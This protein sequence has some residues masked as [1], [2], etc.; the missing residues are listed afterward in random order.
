MD[1]FE[2]DLQIGL[3]VELIAL[4]IIQ[5]K[6]PCAV[7]VHGYKGYDIWIPEI[8]K[9]IEVKSDK[10]SNFTGNFVVEFE[11]NNKKS[12]LMTT[13]A[14]YWLFYDGEYFYCAKPMTIV[15]CI[16]LNKMK[17]AEFVG[18]GDTKA[19]KAFLIPKDILISFCDKIEHALLK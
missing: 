12:G 13:C 10:K 5:K 11:M 2:K 18:N 14:D 19:K 4:E 16:F 1:N 9:S 15:Y 8:T 7:Q 6:Y 3:Q 17:Y